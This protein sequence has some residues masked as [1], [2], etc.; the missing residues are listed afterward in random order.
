[1][2]HTI[3]AII[4]NYNA[5]CHVRFWEGVGGDSPALLNYLHGYDTVSVARKALLA[6]AA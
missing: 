2:S 5:R 4:V 6:G 3:S 1:M